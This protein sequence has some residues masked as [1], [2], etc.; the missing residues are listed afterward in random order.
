MSL[1]AL[2]AILTAVPAAA[3]SGYYL[4]YL[5]PDSARISIYLSSERTVRKL[6]GVEDVE[7]PLNDRRIPKRFRRKQWTV[8]TDK[9][10]LTLH[11]QAFDIETIP[12]SSLTVICKPV[13]ARGVGLVI[14]GPPPKKP[15]GF[16]KA[17][18]HKPTKVWL[19]SWKKALVARMGK[20][21]KAYDY[22]DDWESQRDELVK[23]T[24]SAGNTT[25]SLGRFGGVQH[26]VVVL[27]ERLGEEY[28]SA[29]F[30]IDRKGKIVHWLH[31]PQVYI[32][33]YQVSGLI[34]ADGDGF[35]EVWLN[36]EYYEGGGDELLWLRKK[37]VEV[38]TLSDWGG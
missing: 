6:E 16:R 32:Y 11:A 37:K 1:P 19:D 8:L 29:V 10:A 15:R 7:L 2:V 24:L 22:P 33:R 4:A 35:D 21:K 27:Q 14:P 13:K 38:S 23:L 28:A 17:K 12:E 34:D 36:M 18:V 5:E 30:T 20:R 9:G 31:E 26:G 25:V 3:P